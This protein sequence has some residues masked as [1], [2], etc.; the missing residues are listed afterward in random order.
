MDELRILIIDDDEAD[1]L[2]VANQ[3]RLAFPRSRVEIDWISD[4]KDVNP[5]VNLGTYDL[6]MVD[7]NLGSCQGLDIIHEMKGGG[8]ALPM[9]LLTG[10]DDRR[11]DELAAEYGA[12]D[13]LLKD[14]LTPLL[15]N[16]TVRYAIARKEYE[17]KLIT[18]AYTDD[19]TGLANRKK[20]DESLTT[21][22]NMV[23]RTEKVVLLALIDFDDFKDVNDTFG[24]PAGDEV[25]RAVAERLTGTV[26]RS[27]LVARLGGDEFGLI[28]NTFEQ[29]S[30]IDI[31]MNKVLDIFRQP[32]FIEGKPHNFSASIGVA[33]LTGDKNITAEDLM[34]QADS[35]LYHAKGLGKNSIQ[36]CD[37]E[38]SR[39]IREYKDIEDGLTH[40]L[41]NNALDLY[42]Q[43]KISS[44]TGMICGTEALLRWQDQDGN[45]I[46]PDR[47]IPIAEQSGSI[48]AIG[49]W[50]IDRAC[51]DLRDRINQ[52]QIPVP[53]AVNISALQLQS[54]TIIEYIQSSIKKHDLAPQ[55]LELELTETAIMDNFDLFV[56][57][58]TILNDL[59]FQ[60]SIDDFG[61][62][63]SSLSRLKHFPVSKLKID[64]SFVNHTPDSVDDVAI[65]KIIITLAHNLRLKVV[66]EGV[67]TLEQLSFLS[68]C[69]CDEIQGYYYSKP[70]PGPEYDAWAKSYLSS[71]GEPHTG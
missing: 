65:C 59:G 39:K 52:G 26:R 47:F 61:M 56:N 40:A 13:Y 32:F 14:Q 54:P 62:G 21:S 57:K 25:L 10:L 41:E 63:Y 43:P 4:A 67:E 3:L 51:R 31:L 11:I 48:I 69:D 35:A 19:L 22:I 44:T 36:Y 9:I 37:Q 23:S 29:E 34:K 20:F 6:W 12:A 38:L 17:G 71:M 7:Q 30:D 5:T 70:L 28:A 42:Y 1:Y 46:P 68:A 24:H 49:E 60:I 2:I 8:R 27:D 18:Y 50:V 33:I 58:M 55:Y 64:R 66:A 15:L 45:F 16:K 53:V